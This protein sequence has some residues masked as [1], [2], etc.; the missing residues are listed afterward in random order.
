VLWSER[1]VLLGHVST[2]CVGRR[3][4]IGRHQSKDRLTLRRLEGNAGEGSAGSLTPQQPLPQSAT[5]FDRP[6]PG[7]SLHKKFMETYQGR[8]RYPASSRAS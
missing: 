1:G 5:I 3:F 4:D 7:I 8:R 6:V 2:D